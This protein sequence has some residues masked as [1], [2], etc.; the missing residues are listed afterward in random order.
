MWQ[1]SR[2]HGITTKDLQ[3]SPSFLSL[4]PQIHSLLKGRILVAHSCGTEKRFLRAF[5]GQQFGPWVDSLTLARAAL[6]DLKKHRLGELVP[7]LGE[8][9]DNLPSTSGRK[10][11]DAL[12]DAAA[13]FCFIQTLV[14]T[15]NISDKP[16]SLL[17]NPNVQKYHDLRSRK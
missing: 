10:W 12:Y 5:P 13:S 1:A 3:D 4:F 9:F 7:Y 17:L 8:D 11:H 16:L 6:P 15:L 2:V 14:N